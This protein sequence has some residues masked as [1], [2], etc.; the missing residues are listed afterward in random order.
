M[1][2]V[3][4]GTGWG[5]THKV[6]SQQPENVV[7][8][9]GVYEWTGELTKPTGS[10]F[11]PVTV[12][13]NGELEDAGV[14]RPQPV[15]FALL[16][17]NV[18]EV[19]DAGLSKGMLVLET[20]IRAVK[21][22]GAPGPNFDQGWTAYGTY[23]PAAT[24]AAP[25]PS[26]LKPSKTLPTIQVS[27]G[28]SNKPHLSDRSGDTQP[29]KSGDTH[30]NPPNQPSQQQPSK[31]DSTTST[32]QSGSTASTDDP[33]RPTM[34]RR[35][36]SEDTS[37][38]DTKTSSN[39]DAERPTLKRRSPEEEK[40]RKKKNDIAT[41]TAAGSMTDDPDRPILHHGSDKDREDMESPKLMGLPKD[42]HQ[43]V[44]VSDAKN[45]DPHPFARSW[46]DMNEHTAVMTKMQDFARAQLAA[47]GIVPGVTPANAITGTVGANSTTSPS[48]SS[49]MTAPD[50]GPPTLKRGIPSKASVTTE[51]APAPKASAP[52]AKRSTPTRAGA[53]S[54]HA[55]AAPPPVTLADEVL[56]GYTLS[57]GG[58]PTYV[59]MAHTVE[60]D[61]VMRYVTIV[62]QA[63]AMGNLQVALASVTDATHLDRKPWMRLIDAVDA[64]A[65]NRASLLFEL[66]GQNTR[67]FA[68][69]RVIAAKPEQIFATGTM[70]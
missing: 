59:Y 35:T 3:L 14:Y 49:G 48:S 17:G 52:P 62:A 15:P 45:R 7:R 21:P 68:L 58:S 28:D 66:R 69:Y 22:D 12:F 29:S 70:M 41:V 10:R 27:G 40:E 25:K 53:K 42:M 2:S 16:S 5:Q 31:P 55:P 51:G 4:A 37:T 44:G 8:A 65:S 54:R 11:V 26:H 43:M 46:E 63:D 60:T 23:K 20:A 38:A 33:D 1:G 13:I 39:D 47:Y 18:Y 34:H 64:E 56:K 61:S 6:S 36:E 24:A 50:T 9:V 67:Q 30:S 19:D 57:Y 32:P